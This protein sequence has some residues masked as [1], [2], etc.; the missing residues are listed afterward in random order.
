MGPTPSLLLGSFI[1]FVISRTKYLT[2]FWGSKY[3]CHNYFHVTH[4][5]IPR[6]RHL[7]WPVLPFSE[8]EY[9]F[10]L[11][12]SQCAYKI[13]SITLYCSDVYYYV[14]SMNSEDWNI[15]S[16]RSV[17]ITLSTRNLQ[18]IVDWFLLLFIVCFCFMCVSE[19]SFLTLRKEH[20]TKW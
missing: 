1:L 18:M 7:Q 2:L 20:G 17:H 14:R 15:W 10:M 12:T 9:R 8:D 16:S 6:W 4:I 13:P 5:T 11:T 19:P 3:F